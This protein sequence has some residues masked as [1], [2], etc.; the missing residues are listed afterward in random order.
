MI[1]VYILPASPLN[2]A[3]SPL[4]ACSCPCKEAYPRARRVLKGFIVAD[5]AHLLG[6]ARFL[7]LCLRLIVCCHREMVA[8]LHRLGL[9]VVLDVVYNHTFHSL[10]DGGVLIS[11]QV[12]MT[13]TCCM[14]C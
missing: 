7:F 9:R 11:P 13:P 10:A 2:G 4:Q 14:K 12:V 3:C 8:G 6:F 1:I 5:S